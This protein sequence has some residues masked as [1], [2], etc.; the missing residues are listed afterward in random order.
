MKDE[1]TA[2]LVPCKPCLAADK[3]LC[4]LTG[5]LSGNGASEQ[6]LMIRKLNG[7]ISASIA[8]YPLRVL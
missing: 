6:G 4:R 1:R 2:F 3:I 8:R 5:C 7:Y